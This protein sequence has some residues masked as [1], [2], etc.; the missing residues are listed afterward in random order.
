MD[1]TRALLDGFMEGQQQTG[2]SPLAALGLGHLDGPDLLQEKLE[3]QSASDSLSHDDERAPKDTPRSSDFKDRDLKDYLRS[4]REDKP[5]PSPRELPGDTERHEPEQPKEQEAPKQE[6]HETFHLLN[7]ELQ[8]QREQLKRMEQDQAR[9][10]QEMQ[11]YIQKQQ[12]PA[13]PAQPAI[14][15]YLSQELGIQ[16]PGVLKQY[17]E[18]ILQ[19]ARQE[20]QAHYQRNIA[21]ILAQQQ[22]DRFNLAMSQQK[23]E[24]PHFDKY[25][26]REALCNLHENLLRQHGVQSVAGVNWHQHLRQAYEAADYPRLKAEHEKLLK[27]DKKQE[28]AKEA[29]RAEQKANLSHVP[30]ASTDSGATLSSWKKDIDN[31]PGSLGFRSFGREMLHMIRKKA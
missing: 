16:D 12:A 8:A 15:D 7:G 24:L 5:E 25:F 23:A 13:Q 1:R 22:R 30:K 4:K 10:A 11:Q 29:K 31:L 6:E 17:K 2:G 14:E 28:T 3:G 27:A 21:P 9:R 26:N 19:Q 18:Q 20:Q